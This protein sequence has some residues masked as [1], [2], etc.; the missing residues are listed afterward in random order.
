MREL[1]CFKDIAASL[2]SYGTWGPGK[3]L[4]GVLLDLYA[5]LLAERNPLVRNEVCGID[6]AGMDIRDTSSEQAR[7]RSAMGCT[8]RWGA[9]RE[10]RYTG[11]KAV[12]LQLVLAQA[13]R[14]MTAAIKME[15]DNQ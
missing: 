13:L 11:Q 5:A 6:E 1:T 7:V 12:F 10:T 9:R 14:Q 4:G 2:S 3:R 15:A 8:G